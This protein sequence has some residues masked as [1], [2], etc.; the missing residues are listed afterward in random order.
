M[1]ILPKALKYIF[2]VI[3]KT[4]NLKPVIN[5]LTLRLIQYLK[6][7]LIKNS[8]INN[9]LKYIEYFEELKCFQDKIFIQQKNRT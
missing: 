6:T 3:I 9:N 7:F 8:A 1:F 4:R 2:F 5:L